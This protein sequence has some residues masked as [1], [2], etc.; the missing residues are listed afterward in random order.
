MPFMTKHDGGNIIHKSGL[1]RFSLGRLQF[2][3]RQNVFTYNSKLA[4]WILR[5]KKRHIKI[6]VWKSLSWNIDTS[7]IILYWYFYT[8][9]YVIA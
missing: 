4:N 8:M 3:P 6:V 1:S 9:Q 5:F 2:L 7:F